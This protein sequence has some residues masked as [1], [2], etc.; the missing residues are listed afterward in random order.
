MR[1]NVKTRTLQYHDRRM[2]IVE[3]PAYF[4]QFDMLPHES[5]FEAIKRHTRET[6]Q[7]IERLQRQ[8]R[9]L[10]DAWD[11]QPEAWARDA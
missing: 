5:E 10:G 7:R 2:L 6:Q 4:G 8:A 9:H 3:A 1:N 11:A